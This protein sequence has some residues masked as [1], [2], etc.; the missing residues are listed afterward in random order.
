MNL[1]YFQNLP[2][3]DLHNHLHLGGLAHRLKNKY[4]DSQIEVPTSYDGLTGMIDFIYGTLNKI[5][6]TSTDVTTFMEIAIESAIEDNVTVLEASVDIGLARFFD[7]SIEKVIGVT[8]ALKDKYQQQIDFRPEIG[9]NKDLDLDKV[10]SDGLKCIDSSVFK[11]I[12]LYGQEHNQDLKPFVE[13][14]KNAAKN[15]LTTKVHIGE[16]SNHQ[17]IKE[18]ILL[19]NPDEI[20]HGIRAVDSRE[21]MDLILDRDIRL[22]LCPQSNISLGAVNDLKSHPIRELFDHGINITVNTDDLLLFNA[23]V[24][25]ELF[26]LV[27]S[28]LFTL[29]EVEAIRLNA[30]DRK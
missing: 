24:S 28:K 18:A 22:N 13:L 23:T 12:D 4:A 27:D 30:F 29:E 15:N 16:F 21:T 19:L 11:S 25:R 14:F 5:M 3:A 17:S 1:E 8:A 2:K 20:Q 9:V 6:L 26:N 7:G 10:Y